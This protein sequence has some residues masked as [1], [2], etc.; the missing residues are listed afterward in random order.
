MPGESNKKQPDTNPKRISYIFRTKDALNSTETIH[1]IFVG[2]VLFCFPTLRKT[3]TWV[4]GDKEA[5]QQATVELDVKEV[6]EVGKYIKTK[7]IK[8]EGSKERWK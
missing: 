1:A 2:H 7:K 4:R 8:T 3:I 6:L 5:S